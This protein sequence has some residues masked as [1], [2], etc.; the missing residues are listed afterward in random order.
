MPAP[1]PA[2]FGAIVYPIVAAIYL[3][4]A[5]EPAIRVISDETDVRVQ[6]PGGFEAPNSLLGIIGCGGSSH[7]NLLQLNSE[8]RPTLSLLRTIISGAF[9]PWGA[10]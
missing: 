3:P 7:P 5:I 9:F 1:F 8:S 4:V 10:R 6:Q 2:P